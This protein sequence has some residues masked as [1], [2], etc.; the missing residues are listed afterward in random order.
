MP[1]TPTDTMPDDPDVKIFFSGLMILK[2]VDNDMCEV[3]VHSS[4]PRHFLTIEVRR[5]QEGRPDEIMMRHVGPLAFVP[6][7]QDGGTSLHG[8]QIKKVTGNGP[9]TGIRSFVPN[10]A[11]PDGAPDGLALAID[12]QRNDFHNGNPVVG[13]LGATM[14]RLLDIDPLGGRPSIL[15]SNGVLYTAAK[16][17]PDVE[18]KLTD[19]AGNNIRD[20]APFASLIGAA[21]A[22]EE[23][24]HVEIRWRQQG[25]PKTLSLNRDP[26]M[27]YEIYIVNDP[28]FESD[29]INPAV[30]PTH[31][32]LQEYYKILTRVPTDRQFRLEVTLP[33]DAPPPRGTT[34][35]PCMSIVVGG[36]G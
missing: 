4:A 9:A 12:L 3:F 20:L 27:R 25:E 11:Q 17:R 7:D 28:L 16:T 30:D 5:K 18:I 35:A 26:G 13:N 24:T 23:G 6:T 33:Q 21:I 31:D 1:F 19:A 22:L 2:P 14:F 36:G 34:R 29:D 10:A 32:E 15:L 8:M